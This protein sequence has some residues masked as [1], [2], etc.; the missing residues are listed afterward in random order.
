MARYASL[1]PFGSGV[2]YPRQCAP[3]TEVGAVGSFGLVKLQQNGKRWCRKY[4][5]E[6]EFDAFYHSPQFSA[7]RFLSQ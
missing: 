3:T 5:S 2:F 1:I 4:F 6:A 7:E